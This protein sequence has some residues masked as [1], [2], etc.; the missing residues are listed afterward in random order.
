MNK[1]LLWLLVFIPFLSQA[2]TGLTGINV[3]NVNVNFDPWKYEKSIGAVLIFQ[4]DRGLIY[5]AGT[6]V[7]G[8]TELVGSTASTIQ[9]SNAYIQTNQ[10]VASYYG[11]NILGQPMKAVNTSGLGNVHLE[12]LSNPTISNI[13]SGTL[14]PCTIFT[15]VNAQGIGTASSVALSW[16]SSTNAG[17]SAFSVRPQRALGAQSGSWAADTNQGT[18]LSM[19]DASSGIPTNQWF[20][21]TA[22]KSSSIVAVGNLT[23]GTATSIVPSGEV[24]LDTIGIG[25]R[26]RGTSTRYV[27]QADC[28]LNTIIVF[29]NAFGTGTNTFVG[30]VTI[31]S[32]TNFHKYYNNKVPLMIVP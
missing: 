30:G 31:P 8:W 27:E 13:F 7:Q 14:K 26:V 6:N 23:R 32:I 24:T 22:V 20:F 11:T 29:T 10:P 28:Y 1:I 9:F 15:I 17:A 21:N 19:P 2:Q 5:G 25:A 18:A 16:A 3:T 4:A 12:I